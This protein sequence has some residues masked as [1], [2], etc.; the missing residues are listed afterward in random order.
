MEKSRKLGERW[1]RGRGTRVRRWRSVRRAFL[2]ALRN[3]VYSI[4]LPCV[5]WA[6]RRRTSALSIGRFLGARVSASTS[7][8]TTD[9]LRKPLRLAVC[10]KQHGCHVVY[11]GAYSA[12]AG[13][14]RLLLWG[15]G[16]FR[17]LRPW[18]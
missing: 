17:G 5:Y 8:T 6:I 15:F 12:R 3:G 2:S 9:A 18:T 10:A 1:L 4:L 13:S 16:A 7:W 11:L 14:P